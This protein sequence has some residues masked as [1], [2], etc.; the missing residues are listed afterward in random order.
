MRSRIAFF[1]PGELS[2]PAQKSSG[3]LIRAVLNEY[4]DFT[5]P[6][7]ALLS[8][9]LKRQA[10]HG[11]SPPDWRTCLPRRSLTHAGRLRNPIVAA[12][13]AFGA[14]STEG[15]ETA[16]PAGIAFLNFEGFREQ[17]GGDKKINRRKRR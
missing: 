14:I 3:P 8:N 6:D 4:T 12:P 11:T 15:T 17:A 1:D 10:R 16:L 5:N 9:V 7:R 2:L 13:N